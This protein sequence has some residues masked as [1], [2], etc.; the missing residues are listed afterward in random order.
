[1]YF[2]SQFQQ[3]EKHWDQE[4]YEVK[5]MDGYKERMEAM[6]VS[7]LKKY[8]AKLYEQ[9]TKM[10]ELINEHI[11]QRTYLPPRRSSQANQYRG[12]EDNMQQGRFYN[13]QCYNP[14]QYRGYE[15][16]MPQG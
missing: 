3:G 7:W 9:C 14:N 15:D 2:Q 6:L 16:C 10:D 13:A 11:K 1:M 5:A 4:A 8:D 12:F